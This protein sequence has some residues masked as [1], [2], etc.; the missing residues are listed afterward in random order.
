MSQPQTT[1]YAAQTPNSQRVAITLH[2]LY[3]PH[4]IRLVD[5]KAGEHRQPAFIDVNDQGMTP[6]LETSG[7]RMRQSGAILMSLADAAGQLLAPSGPE[8]HAAIEWVFH[9]L[10][11]SQSASA[12]LFFA[13]TMV[14]TSHGATVSVFEKRLTTYLGHADRALRDTPWLAGAYSIADIALYPVVARR[15]D[16]LS[17]S[18]PHL[19]DWSR[20]MAARAP[21]QCGMRLQPL[22]KHVS[23]PHTLQ[24]I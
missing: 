3:I 11:D 12:S 19:T 9:A 7:V 15:L 23:V 24:G 8:R 6:V 21:V 16:S 10:A 1:L 13:Q 18:L 4:Q 17:T 2:E 5:I 22:Q 20:R 14:A